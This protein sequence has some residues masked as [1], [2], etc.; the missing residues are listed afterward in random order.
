MVAIASILYCA[1]RILRDFPAVVDMRL[2]CR[3][4]VDASQSLA[5]SVQLQAE[6]RGNKKT[7]DEHSQDYT[8]W[9]LV[10]SVGNVFNRL[11]LFNATQYHASLDYFGSNKDNG[12]LF[13]VF[14][15]STEV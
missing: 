5:Q 2:C 12:R 6:V 7:L 9:E 4:Y 3:R 1:V 10:D 14:F 8:K 13:Q 15:F 11:V